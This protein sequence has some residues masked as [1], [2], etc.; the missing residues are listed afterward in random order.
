VAV[1]SVGTG[2]DFTTTQA[3]VNAGNPGDEVASG[4]ATDARQLALS[5]IEAPRGAGGQ[6]NGRDVQEPAVG[7]DL[8]VAR[9]RRTGTSRFG[10]F[11]A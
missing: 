5:A 3:K 7:P 2:G 8:D 9:R 11:S 6:C 1:A 10:K 4:P